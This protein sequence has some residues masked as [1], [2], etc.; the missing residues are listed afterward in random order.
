MGKLA[1]SVLT[2]FTKIIKKYGEIFRYNKELDCITSWKNVQ[3]DPS[4]QFSRHCQSLTL[5]KHK[6]H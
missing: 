3:N 2:Y 6:T 5:R 4:N 1:L